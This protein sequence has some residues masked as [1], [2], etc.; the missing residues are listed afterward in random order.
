MPTRHKEALYSN[1][2]LIC[3]AVPMLVRSWRS[4]LRNC[5]DA[6]AIDFSY[7]GSLSKRD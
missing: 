6:S 3:S 2:G 7:S 5:L 1:Q 4:A